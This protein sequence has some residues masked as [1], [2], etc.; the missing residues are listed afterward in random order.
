VYVLAQEAGALPRPSR[1]ESS[2]EQ[3]GDLLA[4]RV[5]RARGRAGRSWSALWACGRSGVRAC[6]V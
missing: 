6:S 5:V 4:F 2:R 3:L 1:C